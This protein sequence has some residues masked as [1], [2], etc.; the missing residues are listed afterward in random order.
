MLAVMS[1]LSPIHLEVSV[2]CFIKSFIMRGYHYQ[3]N[4]CVF[5]NRATSHFVLILDCRLSSCFRILP[6]SLQNTHDLVLGMWD[7]LKRRGENIDT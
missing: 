7:I 1:S 4:H 5:V 2:V 3:F 6:Y